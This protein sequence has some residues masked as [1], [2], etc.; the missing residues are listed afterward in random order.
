MLIKKK[1]NYISYNHEKLT[2]TTQT[3]ITKNKM[4]I[5]TK[6]ETNTINYFVSILLV[7]IAI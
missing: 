2:I 6:K 7:C 1:E 5:K 3:F 4:N